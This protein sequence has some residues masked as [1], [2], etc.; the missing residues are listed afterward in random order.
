MELPTFALPPDP[1][2]LA[3]VPA[4]P[5]V[6]KEKSLAPIWGDPM[7]LVELRDALNRRSQ[8]FVVLG[9]VLE[10]VQS[11]RSAKRR[12]PSGFAR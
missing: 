8:Q 4:A 6:E 3:F 10:R 7:A 12:S 5:T 1:L 9:M 11:E 2:S